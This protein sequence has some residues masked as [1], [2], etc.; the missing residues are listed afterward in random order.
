MT[1]TDEFVVEDATNE[2]V[3]EIQAIFRSRPG[4]DNGRWA[5]TPGCHLFVARD[6]LGVAAWMMLRIDVGARAVT[7]D[8]LEGWWAAGKPTMRSIRAMRFL[9][10]VLHEKADDLGFDVYCVVANANERHGRV[11]VE[12]FGYAPES[13]VFHRSPKGRE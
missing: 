12:H 11:L 4:A 2:D 6:V 10:T 3:E 8:Q 5:P 9:G 1:S 7:A 13:Q